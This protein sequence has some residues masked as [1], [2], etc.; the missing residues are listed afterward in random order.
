MNPSGTKPLRMTR[1]SSS[2]CCM[3][4]TT[5]AVM[6]ANVIVRTAKPRR[7]RAERVRIETYTVACWLEPGQNLYTYGPMIRVLQTLA[8]ALLVL[9]LAGRSASAGKPQVVILG[10]EVIADKSG[11]IDQETV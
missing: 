2:T 3:F 1:I 7:I 8:L 11:N 6:T 10:L 9:G 4:T 5:V